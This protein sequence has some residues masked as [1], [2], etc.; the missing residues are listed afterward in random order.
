M[1]YI[2]EIRKEKGYTQV[3]MA[4]KLGLGLS[5]YQQKEQGLIMWLL[6]DLI[7]IRKILDVKLDD[8]KEVKELEEK[9]FK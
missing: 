6:P 9:L 3:E 7:K 1:K 4:K 2:G 5:T 8:L